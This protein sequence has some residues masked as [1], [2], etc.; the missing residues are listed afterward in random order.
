MNVGEARRIGWNL[1]LAFFVAFAATNGTLIDG[2]REAFF[3]DAAP[4]HF[5]GIAVGAAGLITTV[6]YFI[7]PKIKERLR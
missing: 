7:E 2:A 6:G 4:I 5:F 3:P 1:L